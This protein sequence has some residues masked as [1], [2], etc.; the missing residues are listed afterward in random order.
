MRT[1]A[2]DVGIGLAIA[3][4][5]LSVIA[6]AIVELIGMAFK[7]RSKDLEIV[8]QDML[9]TGKTPQSLDIY[10]TSIFRVL[11][12]ASRRKRGAGLNESNDKRLPSYVSARAFA[13][14]VIEKLIDL[15]SGLQTG[16][17]L[18]DEIPAGPLRERLVALTAETGG[19]LMQI[20]AGLEGWF[21]DTMDRL[22]GAY[23]RWSR[24]ILLGIGFVLALLLNVSAVRIVDSLWDDGTL[25]DAVAGAAD[26]YVAQQTPDDG[27]VDFS[28]IE[29][30][31]ND[32]EGL[33]LPIGWGS[34]WNDDSGVLLTLLGVPITAV[35]V[36]FGAP[37][38]L[39]ILTRL[40]G[41]RGL[42][43]QPPR[44]GEDPASA[45]ALVAGS[46]PQVVAGRSARG[47]AAGDLL[48]AAIP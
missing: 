11:E 34:G 4:L 28:D 2:V 22:E 14:S 27:P 16:Q 45:T 24:W 42:R 29:Q 21:D 10:S 35:A 46:A 32:L 20:K 43:G 26:S 36:M 40:F 25:R 44:A 47:A 31:V 7:K 1:Q 30:A 37:F 39:G 38:W 6:S 41:A 13:D 8:I 48:D 23:R 19:D 17:R 33:D 12:S 18:M 9:S 5:I 3:F 15:K